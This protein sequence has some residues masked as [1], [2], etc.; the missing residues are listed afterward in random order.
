MDSSIYGAL[1]RLSQDWVMRYPLIDFHGSNGNIAGDGPAHY[2]YTE[3]RISKLTEEG[4]LVG[5]KKNNVDYIDNY[6]ETKKEPI[7]LPALFPN[8]LCNPNSGIGV[9]ISCNWGCANLKET[10]QAIFDYLENKEPILYGDFPTGGIIINKSAYKDIAKTGKGT[11]KIRGRA[12]IE[13]NVII[14]TELPYGVSTESLLTQVGEKCEKGD[15]VGITNIRDESNRKGIRISIECEKGANPHSI[16]NQ[17]F[18]KTDFQINFAYNQVAL[19]DKTPTELNLKD[20]IKIYLNHNK[21]CLERELQFDIDKIK[22]RLHILEGLI[23]ALDIIDDIISMIK[24]SASSSE[25]LLMLQ[26]HWGFSEEQGKAILDMRLAKL[27]KLEKS[28]LIQ[29]QSELIKQ[30]EELQSK[31][32]NPIPEIKTRLADL[33]SKYGDLRRTTLIDL[34]EGQEEEPAIPSEKVVV[35][36]S[37]DGL[38]KRTPSASFKPQRRSTK[39]AKTPSDIAIKTSTADSLM[40]F[41][42]AGLMYR[43]PVADIPEGKSAN[44]KLLAGLDANETPSLIYSIHKDTDAKHVLFVTKNGLVKKTPLEEYTKTKKKGGIAAIS[45]REGDTI[46]A[47]LL[48]KDE[49]L[50]LISK[51]GKLIRTNS[52]DFSPTGRTTTGIKGINLAEG[53]EVAVALAIRDSKDDLAI[54]TKAGLGKRI[55]LSEFNNQKRGGK[56]VSCLSKGELAAAALVQDQDTLLI[57]GQPNSLCVQAAEVP[58]TSRTAGGSLIIKGSKIISVTKI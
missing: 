1:V 43:I 47:V 41:S 11:I 31:M 5:I 51:N 46:A 28:E 23:K 50:L 25:A 48:V 56:G 44:I 3:G 22:Y 13:D 19:V 2:R 10:A 4:L 9:A 35:T 54:F 8:L 14:F 33:V 38:V 45:L 34:G 18:A 32:A 21:K 15:L 57:S 12:Q 29:E 58:V 24:T 40:V 6:S 37:E 53:D 36:L 16:L 7:E 30:K 55:S 26:N 17:L 52:I 49:E 42:T 39:G 20:C 27:S